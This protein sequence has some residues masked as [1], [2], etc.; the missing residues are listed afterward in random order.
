MYVYIQN[1]PQ[2]VNNAVHLA[3]ILTSLS[4]LFIAPASKQNIAEGKAVSPQVRIQIGQRRD[5]WRWRNRNRYN[6]TYTTTRYVRRGWNT[7]RETYQIRY[8]PDGRT[9]TTLVDRVRVS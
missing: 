9:V 2:N 6:R 1:K 7:Y 3:L 5:D 4:F 8:L